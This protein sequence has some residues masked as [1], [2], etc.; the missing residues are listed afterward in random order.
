[1][2]VGVTERWR[3]AWLTPVVM[4][5]TCVFLWGAMFARIADGNIGI[6]KDWLTLDLCG[7]EVVHPALHEQQIDLVEKI[8]AASGD[9]SVV[10]RATLRANYCN[11]YL[12]TSLSIFLAGKWQILFGVSPTENY[13]TFLTRAL[14]YGIT[15]SGELLG[16]ACLLGL[17]FVTAGP[18]RTTIFVTV[19]LGALCDLTVP[20]PITSWFLFQGTP[21]PPAMFVNWL[22]VLGLGLHSWLHPGNAYSAFSVFPRCLCALLSFA[23]FATR[24]SGRP[25]AAYWVLLLIGGIHQSTALILLVALVGCDIVIRPREFARIGIALP[26]GVNLLIALL[27][28]RMLAILGFSLSAV[29]I[30][31]AILLCVVL[32][33]AMVRPVRTAFRAGW[34]FIA[35]WRDRTIAAVPLPFADALVLFAAWFGLILISYLASRDDAWYRVIYFW[36]ELSPRYVGMFQLSVIAGMLYPLVVWMQSARSVTGNVITASVAVVMLAIAISQ[37]QMMVARHGFVSQAI[38]AQAEDYEKATS[39]SR[40]VYAGTTIPT[41]RDETSWYYLLVRNA[42]LGDRSL[43]AF[44]GKT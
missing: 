4:A 18:L 1:M 13:P 25:R 11:N 21:T 14:W 9:D 24:W 43:A 2:S 44:F 39:Q 31:V 41:T 30:A 34:S 6:D 19:G 3:S 5:L 17:F 12:F 27:R 35:A 36:S 42:I 37:I 23:A 7:I 16:I 33:L 32:V 10:Y 28:E 8:V 26:I 40:D 29:V 15:G 20:P 38:T 22:N